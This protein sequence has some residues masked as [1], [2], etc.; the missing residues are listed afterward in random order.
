MKLNLEKIETCFDLSN[1]FIKQMLNIFNYAIIHNTTGYLESHHIIPKSWYK[2]NNISN[3]DIINNKDNL[4]KLTPRQHLEIHV[5]LKKYYQSINDLYMVYAMSNAINRMC[6]GNKEFINA[7]ELST[8][9]K[10]YYLDQYQKNRSEWLKLI[11]LF[12]RPLDGQNNPAYGRI[13]I[14]NDVLKINKFIKH[15][16]LE[17]FLQSGWILGMN[18]KYVNRRKQ[19]KIGIFNCITGENAFVNDISKIEYPWFKGLNSKNTIPI[20]DPI[21]HETKRIQLLT[22]LPDGWNY[23]L[24]PNPLDFSSGV[25][26]ICNDNLK[27]NKI[28]PKNVEIPDGWKQGF[29]L[30]DEKHLERSVRCIKRVLGNKYNLGKKFIFNEITGEIKKI[31]SNEKIPTGWK[32]GK[33]KK[34]SMRWIHNPKTLKNTRIPIDKPLPTGYKEGFL[35]KTSKIR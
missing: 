1:I 12:H 35:R 6:T 31:S 4:I 7:I 14:H 10:E 22:Q 26:R 23:G 30:S 34:N 20:H 15:D 17:T 18:G 21:L 28:W 19:Q 2:R 32:L 5:L 9:D 29:Y 33:Q 3:T 27:K 13:W 24:D 25:I 8:D 11:K 16:Q